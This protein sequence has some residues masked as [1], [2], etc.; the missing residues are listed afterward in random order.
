MTSARPDDSDNKITLINIGEVRDINRIDDDTIYFYLQVGDQTI[1]GIVSQMY[2]MPLQKCI[3][4]QWD[5][6][7][8][9]NEYNQLVEISDAVNIV[10]GDEIMIRDDDTGVEEQHIVN[11]VVDQNTITTVSP[12]LSDFEG[13]NTRVFR[14]QFP[15]PI[16]EISARLATSYIYD[17]YFSA[18]NSPNIS[19]YGLEMRKN[20]TGKLN[21]ILNGRIILRCQ[22]R[23]GDMWG[24]PYLDDTYQHR[25]RGYDSTGR[26]QSRPQQ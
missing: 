11:S 3:N 16:S 15:P 10:R 17:K 1:D 12:I 8:P 18:Q 6:D 26:D 25:D 2:Q 14:L 24:N 4:G 13:E 23:I 19:D 7:A 21:D 9:I 20:A 22:R 5:L